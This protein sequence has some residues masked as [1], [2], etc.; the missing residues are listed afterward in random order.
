MILHEFYL[1]LKE[2]NRKMGRGA[3]ELTY[4]KGV[5]T[6]NYARNVIPACAV[7]YAQSANCECFPRISSL[8]FADA[9]F[10]LVLHLTE[11]YGL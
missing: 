6:N 10:F 11:F 4:Q 2:W 5:L 3:E 7:I 9:I 8:L 1:V